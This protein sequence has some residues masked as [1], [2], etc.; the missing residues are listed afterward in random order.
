MDYCTLPKLPY[1]FDSL[2]PVISK[3]ILE[4][5]YTK[6]HQGYVDNFN[7]ALQ[8]YQEAF[9]KKDL[10]L[11]LSLQPLLTFHGGGHWNHTFF[12]NNLSPHAKGM[13]D[14]FSRIIDENLGSVENFK[15]IFAVRTTAVFGSGWG[16]LAY[17]K[18]T[19][20]MEVMTTQ[21]HDNPFQVGK[22]PLMV[23][24]VWEHAYYLQYKNQ[25]ARFVQE[26]WNVLNW[27]EVEKRYNMAV[28]VK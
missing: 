2:E 22:M 15:E 23:V 1:S 3:E 25:R 21:N 28:G 5:H 27:Q 7:K 13:T 8:K 10:S 26:I 4:L 18:E 16:W 19:K 20:K 17:D 24:D 12:W 11:M 6:H 14:S 9:E